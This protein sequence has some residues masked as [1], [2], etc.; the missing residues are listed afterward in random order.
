MSRLNFAE[1][2]V[3]EA[4]LDWLDGLGYA[5]AYGPDLLPGGACPERPSDDCREVLLEGRV[6]AALG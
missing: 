2:H 6:R 1:S 5:K 3:E 4:T